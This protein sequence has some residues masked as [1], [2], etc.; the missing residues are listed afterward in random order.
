MWTSGACRVRLSPLSFVIAGGHWDSPWSRY[1]GRA[2]SRSSCEAV[3]STI[4]LQPVNLFP[5]IYGWAW[6]EIVAC[7]T[8]QNRFFIFLEQSPFLSVPDANSLT[9]VSKFVRNLEMKKILKVTVISLWFQN[10][11]KVFF[12]FIFEHHKSWSGWKKDIWLPWS[13]GGPVIL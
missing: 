4:R 13:V 5:V 1:I 8:P 9:S 3:L 11:G 2:D 10:G 12:K 7:Q 6:C